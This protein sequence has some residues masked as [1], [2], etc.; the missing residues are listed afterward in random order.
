MHPSTSEWMKKM[1]C[2]HTREY[3][4]A[5]KKSELV[6]FARKWIKLEIN[7]TKRDRYHMFSFMYRT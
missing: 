7:H 1:W 6:S 4:P 3:Y 2:I 5:I